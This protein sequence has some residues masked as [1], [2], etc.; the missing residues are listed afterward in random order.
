MAKALLSVTFDGLSGKIGGT[1]FTHARSGVLVSRKRTRHKQQSVAQL[2]HYFLFA[3]VTNLWRILSAAQRQTYINQAPFY[4]YIDRFGQS[5]TY[6]PFQLFCKVNLTVADRIDTV[7]FSLPAPGTLPVTTIQSVTAMVGIS[8]LLIDV[9][10]PLS[11]S[12][13]PDTYYI[14]EATAP[15]STGW[16]ESPRSRFREITELG[17]GQTIPFNS[18]SEYVDVFGSEN[19]RVGN[20]FGV[21]VHA[22]NGLTGQKS[23]RISTITQWL[24]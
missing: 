8:S 18:Y 11:T 2:Q 17:P 4:S 16:I 20:F 23:I 12:V 15:F 24:P 19:V 6:T 10:S 7:I 9:Y 5:K 21:R 22:I 13:P 1:V 14:I 3:Q